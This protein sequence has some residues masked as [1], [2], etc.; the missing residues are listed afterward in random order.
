MFA[1]RCT[2]GRVVTAD[3]FISSGGDGRAYH[4]RLERYGDAFLKVF[5]M[6]DIPGSCNDRQ[7]H[8]AAT[9]YWRGKARAEADALL[10]LAP[11]GAAPPILATVHCASSIDGSPK[12]GAIVLPFSMAPDLFGVVEQTPQSIFAASPSLARRLLRQLLRVLSAAHGRGHVHGDLRLEQCLLDTW[13]LRRWGDASHSGKATPSRRRAAGQ[14]SAGSAPEVQLAASALRRSWEEA[15][16][17]KQSAAQAASDGREG[18]QPTASAAA[19]SDSC[20]TADRF[21][22]DGHGDMPSCLEGDLSV[23]SVLTPDDSHSERSR[24]GEPTAPSHGAAEA[25]SPALGRVDGRKVDSFGVGV[26]AAYLLTRRGVHVDIEGRAT[27]F[28]ATALSDFP[29]AASFV[30]ALTCWSPASRLTAEEALR[31]PFLEP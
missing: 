25:D 13:S 28:D 5:H 4:G 11:L 3:A 7:E 8:Q 16:S 9:D 1:L 21:D 15:E 22:H 6:A 19:C 2:D 12:L 18:E 31:H 26:V 17:A 27:S 29:A 24:S 10:R 20:W 14:A 23:D 30:A